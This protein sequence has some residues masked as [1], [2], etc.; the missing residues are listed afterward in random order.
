MEEG[1]M[2]ENL[3]PK[4]VNSSS[5]PPQCTRT[6]GNGCSALMSRNSTLNF[7]SNE[8]T[9][10][11]KRRTK[12]SSLACSNCHSHIADHIRHGVSDQLALGARS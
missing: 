8:P 7:T 5:V 10:A 4:P 11:F 12:Y 1:L 9:T 2:P 3:R 6:K